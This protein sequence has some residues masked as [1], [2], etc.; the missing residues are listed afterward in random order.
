MAN[1][2]IH[3]ADEGVTISARA[4]KRLLLVEDEEEESYA[5]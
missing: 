3:T 4:A 5:G 1:V 2:L